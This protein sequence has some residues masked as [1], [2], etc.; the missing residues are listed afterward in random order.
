[1][2]PR[3]AVLTHSPG[4]QKMKRMRAFVGRQTLYQFEERDGDWYLC[5]W[6]NDCRQAICAISSNSHGFSY[7]MSELLSTATAH[8]VEC[9]SVELTYENYGE[10]YA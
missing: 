5:C 6:R 8:H 4:Y 9:H 2:E 7:T 1:M 10:D 3:H